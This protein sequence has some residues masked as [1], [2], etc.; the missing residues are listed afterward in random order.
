MPPRCR[1]LE[2][3][4]VYS[5]IPR[6]IVRFSG[7][8]NDATYKDFKTSPQPV[9]SGN[10]TTPADLTGKTLAGAAK[11]TWNIGAE[12]RQLVFGSKELHAAFNTAFTSRYNPDV[13]LSQY[14]WIPAGA[15][16]DISIGVGAQ[17][18]AYDVSLLVKNAFNNQ[19]H[20]SQSWNSYS[21]AYERWIGVVFS[22]KL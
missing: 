6:T 19:N 3:D 7:A 15:I 21:P 20:V 5:G 12:Y 16:I 4:G 13:A 10:I 17:N 18:K 9:E 22:G 14:A 11:I 2:V 8:Y 1:R